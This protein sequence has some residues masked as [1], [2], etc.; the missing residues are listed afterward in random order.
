MPHHQRLQS[1]ILE[2]GGCCRTGR[3]A[4]CLHPLA[5]PDAPLRT[6]TC[7]PPAGA[8][9]STRHYLSPGE[10]AWSLT[11]QSDGAPSFRK[12][13]T[14]PGTAY[15][16]SREWRQLP[17]PSSRT[18]VM[19][20]YNRTATRSYSPPMSMGQEVWRILIDNG[21]ATNLLFTTAFEAMGHSRIELRQAG[22]PLRGFEGEASKHLDTLSSPSLSDTVPMLGRHVRR[23]GYPLPLQCHLHARSV[24]STN[25]PSTSVH[26]W[27]ELLGKSR[28]AGGH[29]TEESQVLI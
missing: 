15:D 19:R 9:R 10:E 17:S 20:G 8:L 12:C 23:R 16:P 29:R 13:N 2:G 3:A 14:S 1:I 22:S 26:A 11:R 25:P 7:L 21:S 4:C 18:T 28:A 24:K 27:W 6:H 5:A